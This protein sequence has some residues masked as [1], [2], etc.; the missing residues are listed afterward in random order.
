MIPQPTRLYLI[1]HAATA[2]SARGRCIGRTDAPLSAAGLAAAE[3]VAAGFGPLPVAAVYSSRLQRALRT[4]APIAAAVGRQV[5]IVDDLAEIDFGTLEGRRL[6][7]I[8]AADP[9]LYERWMT[10]PAEVRFP[11]GESY[12][13]LKARAVASIRQI[14]ASHRGEAIVV[15]SHGGPIRTV[16]AELLGMSDHAGFE[17]EIRH[18]AVTHVGWIGGS[19]TVHYVNALAVRTGVRT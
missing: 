19:P 8:A 17:L 15:V 2:E 1:R 12:A 7:E 16:L 11:G 5:V 4:A 13:E 6:D 18:A 9:E 3:Q 14:V 10:R